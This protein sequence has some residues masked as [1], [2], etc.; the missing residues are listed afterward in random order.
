MYAKLGDLTLLGWAENIDKLNL[1]EIKELYKNSIRDN[2]AYIIYEIWQHNILTEKERLEF[3]M[4]IIKYDN[5]ILC[6]VIASGNLV[7][8]Y[9]L[10]CKPLEIEKI[11]NWWSSYKK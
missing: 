2:K 9:S 8:R 1:N 6:V 11:L 5:S 10:N 3:N 4:E 7:E